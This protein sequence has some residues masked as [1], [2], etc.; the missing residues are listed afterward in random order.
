[1]R[2]HPSTDTQ[3]RGFTLIELMVVV[4]VVA[5]LGLI[6]LPS[7]MDAVRKS[8]R[9]DAIEAVT[10]IQQAQERWRANHTSY[11][12]DLTGAAE[13]GGLGLKAQSPSGYYALSLD[14]VDAAG[15]TVIAQAKAGTSQ[16]AD[17]HCQKLVLRIA[18]G[19]LFYSSV[20]A[21]DAADPT[22][23]KR[24]WNR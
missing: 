6:A 21:G 23:A 16:A 10:Q 3:R 4:A 12:N 18:G 14:N 19:N 7:F 8:R 2:C 5:I 1:M 11:S 17:S 15:Y 9:S 22:D 24:C 13:G 20:G